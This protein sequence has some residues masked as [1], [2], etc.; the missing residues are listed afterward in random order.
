ML[1]PLNTLNTSTANT[2]TVAKMLAVV[3]RSGNASTHLINRS[4]ITNIYLLPVDDVGRGPIMSQDNLSKGRVASIVPSGAG[5]FGWGRLCLWHH[6]DCLTQHST[7]FS[8]P[9]Q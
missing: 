9:G 5:G 3:S 8:Y 4:V 1:T 7:S 6:S 2:L